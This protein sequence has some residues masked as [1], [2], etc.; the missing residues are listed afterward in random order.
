LQVV[1]QA[2]RARRAVALPHHELG[3]QPARVARG[4]QADE[5]TDAPHVLLQAVELLAVLLGQ[6]PA[7]AGGDRIDEDGVRVVHPRRLV[8]H[9]PPGGGGLPPSSW[10]GG[11]RGA[12]APMCSHTADEPGPPLKQKVRGRW[13]GS[14][15]SSRVYAT[16]KNGALGDN[17]S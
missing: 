13:P 3:R 1:R 12:I 10:S 14:F 17:W 5:L 6:R 15:T 2:R 9:Q 16:K 11:R 8:A 7:V 4:V